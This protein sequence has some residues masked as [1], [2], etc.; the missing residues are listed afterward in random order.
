VSDPASIAG[1]EVALGASIGVAMHA[2]GRGASDELVRHADVA[3]YAAKEAG[4]GRWELF[5]PEMA[6]ELGEQLGLEYD[7]RMALKRGEL[8]VHYQPEHDLAS[9]TIVGVEALLRW[10]HPERGSISP[11]DFIPIAED[12]G[13]IVPI[14]EWVL[15]TAC[16]EMK[17]LERRCGRR[18]KVAV[19]LSPRQL[20]IDLTPVIAQALR[21]S[22]WQA[23]DLE[24]EITESTMIEQPERSIAALQRLRAMGVGLSIDDFGTGYSSLSYLA[25]LP[26]AKLKLDRSFVRGLPYSERDAAIATSVVALGHGLKLQVL[27]EGIETEA[28]AQ[29]LRGLGC[30]MGQGWLFA[31]PMPLQALEQRLGE[32]DEAAAAPVRV[33]A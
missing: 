16:F 3:M 14:G 31:K 15:R 27:A 6:R 11:A 18:L 9:R 7:L 2:G 28:Q 23:G 29:F 22:G 32:E 26:V 20:R 5:R 10:T 13:L 19:N 12:T 8:S 21:D 24:L 25:R 4:R 30:Q 33:R 17:E 1:V